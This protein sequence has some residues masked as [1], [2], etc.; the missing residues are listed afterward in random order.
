M[1]GQVFTL[2]ADDMIFDEF[3]VPHFDI[4]NHILA[5]GDFFSLNQNVKNKTISSFKIIASRDSMA[6][7]AMNSAISFI[8]D[9]MGNARANG[10]TVDEYDCET[11]RNLDLSAEEIAKIEAFIESDRAAKIQAFWNQYT[12]ITWEVYQKKQEYDKKL[13]A[14]YEQYK[15]DIHKDRFHAS[16]MDANDLVSA[17]D[18]GTFQNYMGKCYDVDPDG[19]GT[20]TKVEWITKF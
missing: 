11:N 18:V 16:D 7:E 20:I 15:L 2:T 14:Y 4:T 6:L 3:H 1:D 9:E 8:E 5:K 19:S 13:D 12:T 17:D 10:G